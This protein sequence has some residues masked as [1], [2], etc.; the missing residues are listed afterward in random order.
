MR[1]LQFLS[2]GLASSLTLV[3][4]RPRQSET[5]YVEPEPMRLSIEMNDP[6]TVERRQV[7]SHIATLMLEDEWI[8]IGEQIAE[9]EANLASTPGGLR[10]HEIAVDVALSG[11]QSLID[12]AERNSLDDLYEAELEL[13]CFIETHRSA[14][15]DH[16]LALLAARAHLL[17][18]IACRADHW[19]DHCQRDAWRRMAKHYV[20]AGEILK[21][22]DARALM[23]PLMGEAKY[24]QGLG[25][26]GQGHRIPELFADWIILDPS[27][28][29]IYAAHGAWLSSPQH[30]SDAKILEL[31]EEALSRTEATLGMGGYA[32]FF[33]PLLGTRARARHIYDPDLFASAIYDLATLSSTQAEVNRMAD[34]LAG[35]IRALGGRAPI[36]LRDT[37]LMLIRN[38]LTVI[39]PKVWSIS[40]EA[41]RDLIRDARDAA[42]GDP[43]GYMSAA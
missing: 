25:S 28:L 20:A 36:A 30:A 41:I 22:Y 42:V 29:A 12:A 1:V 37:L 3:L 10:Y 19:P 14:P 24:M 32:L 7:A 2:S 39:Y 43:G 26:P 13:D 11:L 4:G 9:W 40:D 18:G 17:L 6:D 27:N 31:A 16:V 35:E 23:S 38:E 5:R 15:S 34:T 33:Q 8:E 21:D